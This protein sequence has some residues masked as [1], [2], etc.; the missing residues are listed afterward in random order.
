MKHIPLILA[1]LVGVFLAFCLV[2]EEPTI[3]LWAN[4]IPTWYQSSFLGQVGFY[5]KIPTFWLIEGV[6]HLVHLPLDYEPPKFVETLVLYSPF[7]TIA[8]I[9]LLVFYIARLL[10]RHARPNT[11]GRSQAWSG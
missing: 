8:V 6:W 3:W 9:S 11:Y 2:F 4:P 1:F 10:L 7:L 5:M